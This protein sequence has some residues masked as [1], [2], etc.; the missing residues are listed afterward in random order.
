MASHIALIERSNRKD[1]QGVEVEV[2]VREPGN[3]RASWKGEFMSRSADGF[4]P[5]ERL[6]L[7][8]DTGEKG[9]ARVSE[10]YFDSRTPGATR[11]TFS[12]MG[13]LV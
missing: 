10:T 9:I 7:T 13:P 2:T 11:V 5:D 6:A 3:G 4:V 1:L 8:L 12:G